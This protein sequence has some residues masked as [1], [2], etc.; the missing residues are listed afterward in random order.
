MDIYGSIALFAPLDGIAV[1]LIILAWISVGFAIDNP[2]T[3]HPSVSILMADYRRQWMRQHVSRDPRVFDALLVSNL[4]QAAAFFASTCLV[5]FGG[6]LALL[7][8][9]DQWANVAPELAL[10]QTPAIVWDA[11]IF[12]VLFFLANGLF[13]F[14][15]AHRLFGYCAVIMG[16]IPNEI[17]DLAYSRAT[18]AGEINVTAARSFNR[19]IRAIYFALGALAWLLGPFALIVATV[20]TVAILWRRE[21]ASHSRSVLLNGDPNNEVS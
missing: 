18:Q 10:D 2:K 4:R 5:A 20:I 13:K 15:W 8:N 7:G 12:L 3:A 1:A 17:N 11:R 19:G 21:F 6:G 14:V 9:P 16:S